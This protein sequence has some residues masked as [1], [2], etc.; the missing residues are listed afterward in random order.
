MFEQ[1]VNYIK[2]KFSK[3][4]NMM[5]KDREIENDDEKQKIY[6]METLLNIKN[7]P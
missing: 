6:C 1:L 2:R 5:K 7:L 3:A 4:I